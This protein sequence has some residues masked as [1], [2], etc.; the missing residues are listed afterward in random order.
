M[1]SWTLAISRICDTHTV[2]VTSYSITTTYTL[3]NSF[4]NYR[5]SLCK[6]QAELA[7]HLQKMNITY[8]PKTCFVVNIDIHLYISGFIAPNSH[9]KSSHVARPYTQ[10]TSSSSSSRSRQKKKKKRLHTEVVI[11]SY[12]KDIDLPNCKLSGSN[13]DKKCSHIARPYTQKTSSSSSS[14]RSPNKIIFCRHTQVVLF[15]YL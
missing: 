15:S 8:T 14:S 1:T 10:K 11:F 9:K 12:C 13:S 3:L 4:E 2:G 7:S 6:T 5:K